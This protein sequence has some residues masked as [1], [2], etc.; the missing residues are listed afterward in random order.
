M[1][2]SST[3]SI[4]A[5]D[6]ERRE[7]GVAV[8]SRFLAIGA[9][10]A[11]AEADVGAVATQS[12]MNTDY[13]R[14]GLRLIANGLCAREAL[15]RVL[16]S[17]PEP[18]KRQV[19]VVDRDG[20]V[21]GHTGD[22][23]MPWAGHRL[24]KGFAAQG[25]MLVSADTVD[26][27]ADTFGSTPGPLARRLVAALVAAQAAGG[28]RR[29][30]QSAALIVAR[31]GGG[32]GGADIAVDL[33]VDDHPAPLRELE[34]LLGLHE[35]Y[36]GATPTDCWLPV[37]RE[38][39]VEVR[40]ALARLGYATGD[41]GVDLETWAGIENLEERVDGAARV[42]PVVLDELR[43]LASESARATTPDPQEERH[44]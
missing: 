38:L 12:F 4:V 8:Q 24:G 40:A 23:C 18:D 28:D 15:D 22:A 33:R 19:G 21:A 9:L 17:D 34:R 42:D 3:Y 27:L 36:F 32:Y 43:R 26:A 1:A 31:R 44:G 37:G 14:T 39:A 6:L 5:C 7:W 10:A 35:L 30:Q 20:T 25:N 16:A 13:G 29:G 11:W 41:L 2:R